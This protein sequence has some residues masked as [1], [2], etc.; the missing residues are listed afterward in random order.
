M[1]SQRQIRL[2]INFG[3]RGY[4]L[5]L[6]EEE[7]T[8]SPGDLLQKAFH[9]CGIANSANSGYSLFWKADSGV[10][11]YLS[12]DDQLGFFF[13]MVLGNG[14]GSM[15]HVFL[16]QTSTMTADD[17]ASSPNTAAEM[18]TETPESMMSGVVEGTSQSPLAQQDSS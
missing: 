15:V 18:R 10:K 12:S 14:E 4:F 5:F 3:G 9:Q 7:R 1:T 16:E 17:L 6:E 11:V 13:Q 2:I 8:I